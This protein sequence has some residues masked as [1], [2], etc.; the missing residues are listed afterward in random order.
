MDGARRDRAGQANW[1]GSNGL[2]QNRIGSFYS[3]HLFPITAFPAAANLNR[4]LK[5]QDRGAFPQVAAATQ[6]SRSQLVTISLC[7]INHGYPPANGGNT[8]MVCWG[9]STVSPYRTAT[10][11]QRNE[12]LCKTRASSSLRALSCWTSAVIVVPG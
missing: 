3:R 6:P 11:S 9:L 4:A 2:A 5:T 10:P 8:S 1:L 7:D 12:H